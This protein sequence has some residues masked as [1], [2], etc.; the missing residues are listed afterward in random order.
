MPVSESLRRAARAA[1]TRPDMA[2]PFEQ[3]PPARQAYWIRA[4]RRALE[5]ALN[6]GELA[7]V[8]TA[9][10]RYEY[11]PEAG[12]YRCICGGYLAS[13]WAVHIATAIRAH[14]LGH[15]PQ[16]GTP[17]AG[18]TQSTTGDGAPERGDRRRARLPHP[19]GH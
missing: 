1:Y 16:T 14:V 8:I 5:A 6:L 17:A 15:D 2:I 13:G 19:G 3:R 7:E 11:D 9:H 18:G 10:S 12:L 4:V